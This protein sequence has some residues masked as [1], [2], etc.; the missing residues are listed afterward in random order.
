METRHEISCLS[1][2]S[3]FFS[4]SPPWKQSTAQETQKLHLW[5]N[6]KTSVTLNHTKWRC[7]ALSYWLGRVKQEE[8]VCLQTL[9]PRETSCLT[10]ENLREVQELEVPA[11]SEAGVRHRIERRKFAWKYLWK[12]WTP[13]GP[14]SLHAHSSNCNPHSLNASKQECKSHRR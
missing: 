3:L 9:G 11:T 2:G 1:W 12:A 7:K 14:Y 8:P 13:P 10:A 5:W 4:K 6:L